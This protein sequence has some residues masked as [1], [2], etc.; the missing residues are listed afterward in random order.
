MN[1]PITSRRRY[2][3]LLGR[4]NDRE[5]AAAQ[6]KPLPPIEIEDQA[7]GLSQ[8]AERIK[9]EG[10]GADTQIT[11]S[12]LPAAV[13]MALKKME[14]AEKAKPKVVSEEVKKEARQQKIKISKREEVN[15]E[16]KEESIETSKEVKSDTKSDTKT[17]VK[18]ET[19]LTLK[20][21]SDKLKAKYSKVGLP[22]ELKE[23]ITK[24]RY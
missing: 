5:N 13:K 19:P 20:E 11:E 6:K 14:E 2:H 10:K 4:Y 7:S 18:E 1:M 15:N 17:E 21:A 23:L 9:G 22:A 8:M 3:F 16:V 24:K 12:V